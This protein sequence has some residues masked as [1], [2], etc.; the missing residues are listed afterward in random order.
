MK[1]LVLTGADAA[2]KSVADLT[3]PVAEAYALRHGYA[4]ERVT[5]YEPGTHPSWQKL[6]LI[7]ERLSLFDR[8]FWLDADTVVTDPL[9]SLRGFNHPGLTVSTDWTWPMPEDEIKH[10]SLG[11]FVFN[12]CPDSF[13]IIE[14]AIARSEWANVGLWEQQAIQEE[15]RANPD[16]RKH[17]LVLPRRALNAVV[18][19]PTTA[20]PEPWQEGDFLAHLTNLP[21]EERVRL[22]PS[23]IQAHMRT[24]ISP[25]GLPA[26]HETMMSMDTRHI[27]CL[28]ELLRIGFQTVAEIG[29]W[30]GSASV[31]FCEALDDEDATSY[32]ACD[33]GFQQEFLDVVSRVDRAKFRLCQQASTDFLKEETNIDF[34]FVDGDHSAAT[35][36]AEAELILANP[37]LV[38]CGHDHHAAEVGFGNCEGPAITVEALRNDGWTIFEDHADR[39]GEVTKRGFYAATKYREIMPEIKRAFALTCF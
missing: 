23:L 25:H 31:A 16:I 18:E 21:N 27:A 34:L 1:T 20:G 28:R 17:V 32:L 3:A 7:K 2:M 6:R 4:F 5:K 13:E 37:P 36:I 22:I 14:A 30:K 29:V 10:F 39:P 35:G 38:I 8:I 33:V 11:N 24:V 26:H 12:Q 19:T 15:Y 9:K